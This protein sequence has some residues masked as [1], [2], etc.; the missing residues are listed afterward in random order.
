MS[1]EDFD[2][3]VATGERI[4]AL[5]EP[6]FQT[7]TVVRL[8]GGRNS[9]VFEVRSRD[10]RSLV[11]KLYSDRFHWKMEKEVFVYER[12][13][14]HAL[15]ATLP[16]ILAADDSK[17]L[18]SQNV[19]VMTK[20]DGKHVDSLIANL[21]ERDLVEIN[22]QVGSTLAELHRI[23][24][25]EFGYVGTDGVVEGH[26]TNL[27]YMSFQFDK[28]LREFDEHGGDDDLRRMIE[29]YVAEREQLLTTPTHP[30]FC[31]ND[32]YYGNVL[33]LPEQEGWRVSGLVDFENVLA[34]DPLLDLAKTHGYARERR[35]EATLA[36]LAEGHGAL[37]DNWREALDLYVLYHWIEL[38]DWFAYLGRTEPLAGLT[39]DI[40]Q[41]VSA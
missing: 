23:E 18:V 9:A 19:L 35:S 15:T 7:E 39:R 17:E 22:R 21:D 5:A 32:C 38:W 4:V 8:T 25:A 37:R 12:M 16:K 26:A 28:K 31:H 13:Q 20:V 27:A 10:G 14:Q 2:L 34:G 3:D 11:V 30:A 1:I 24:F 33:V 6:G 41:L 36:A 40:S 29:R